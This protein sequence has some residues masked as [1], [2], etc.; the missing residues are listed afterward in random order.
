MLMHFIVA[1]TGVRVCVASPKHRVLESVWLHLIL[2]DFIELVLESVWLHL[3]VIVCVASPALRGLVG[4][5][6]TTLCGEVKF[7]NSCMW[8]PV[9]GVTLIVESA[10]IGYV[11]IYSCYAC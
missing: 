9:I 7:R 1:C 8:Q 11:R 5:G 3:G 10:L 6:P 4:V 2:R